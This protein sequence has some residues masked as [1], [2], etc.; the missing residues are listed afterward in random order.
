M[1]NAQWR[2]FVVLGDGECQEGSVWE[3]A[4]AAANYKLDHLYVVIDRNHLQYD[5]NTENVMA[6][7]DFAEKWRSFGWEVREV[8][9]HDIDRLF[10]VLSRASHSGSPIVVIA[11]TIKGKGV[12]FMENNPEWH[13]HRLTQAE[14]ESAIAEV[15]AA[16]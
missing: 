2:T 9:G 1:H 14:Y 12:S 8:E 5:D 3:A 16:L 7:G 4:M 13:H 11:D 15:E 6:L 10:P